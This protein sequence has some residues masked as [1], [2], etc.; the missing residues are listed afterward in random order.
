MSDFCNR[1]SNELWGEDFQ[2]EIDV[3]KIA[4]SLQP[5]SYMPVLCEG[6][7]MSAIGKN[8]KGEVMIAHVV[9]EG[10][11]DDLVEWVPYSDWETRPLPF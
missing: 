6:C 3:L 1:C 9:E 7:G 5:N 4:E 2:P 10:H 8:E 11:V